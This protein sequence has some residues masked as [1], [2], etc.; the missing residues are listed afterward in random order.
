MN[1]LEPLKD[2]TSQRYKYFKGLWVSLCLV[3]V[4]LATWAKESG[5]SKWQPPK[6]SE[7]SIPKRKG[8]CL[9][10]CSKQEIKNLQKALKGAGKSRTIVDDL[11]DRSEF[12]IILPLSFPERGGQHNQWYQCPKCQVGL[13]TFGIKDHRCPKCGKTY[14]GY[15]YD[16]VVF[17]RVHELNMHRMRDCAWSYA[18]SGHKQYAEHAKNI[19]LG[20]AERY[21][22]YP[23]HSAPRTKSDWAKKAGGHLREQTLN[24]ADWLIRFLA[25]SYDLIWDASGISQ[26]EHQKIQEKLF[27]PMLKNIYKHRAGKTNWQAY[28]NAALLLGGAL[29]GDTDMVRGSIFDTENGFLHQMDV[30]VSSHGM[31][32]EGSW[33]YHFYAL[34]ALAAIAIGAKRIG[35]DLWHNPKL[36]QMFT[37]PVHYQMPDGTLPRLA[38]AIPMTLDQHADLYEQ[39]FYALKL[40]ELKPMLTLE[41]TFSSIRAGRHLPP[42]T[43]SKSVKNSLVTQGDGSIV[44]RSKGDSGM[45]GCLSYNALANR[46]RHFD[47]LSF[48]LYGNGQEMAV[49]PGRATDI[50]YRLPVHK[51]WYRA[52]LG[53][54]TILVGGASQGPG[55]GFLETAF[56]GDTCSG[57]VAR[58]DN[59]Y[60]ETT[61][62]RLFVLAEEYAVVVDVV[63]AP[64]S[65]TFDWLYHNRGKL[66]EVSGRKIGKKQNDLQGIE[67]VGDVVWYAS[68][69]PSKPHQFLFDQSQGVR[70]SVLVVSEPGDRLMTGTGPGESVLDRV[71]MMLVR[72]QGKQAVFL[73][74]IDPFQHARQER[75]SIRNIET[76]TNDV[77]EIRATV[78]IGKRKDRLEWHPDKQVSVKLGSG[79]VVKVEIGSHE[80][81]E[82][83]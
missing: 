8:P 61:H 34:R 74:V 55:Q 48:V 2:A 73:A 63:Q 57:V 80:K 62:Q 39:A 40:V 11:I 9:V 42:K 68:K 71:P 64:N 22:T 18:V 7:I 23:Y 14:V 46:H 4:P 31:W 1:N 26:E 60:P 16:D 29:V 45:A 33:G 24:E 53:H 36:I 44:L 47:A 69:D 3:L 6:P 25:P 37:Q 54:N 67:F 20:Y 82:R 78:D 66:I 19:L 5:S 10:A 12:W 59:A 13:E 52:T 15:P 70:T 21:T 30:S 65:T 50:A 49:D 81:R 77:G 79:C 83:D 72:K 38:D 17:S 41:P 75:P 56:Q 43:Y 58:V 35:T 51:N 27:A 32:Y 28:H 76:Q